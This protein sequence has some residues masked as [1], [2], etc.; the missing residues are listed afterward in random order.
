MERL[1]CLSVGL[2]AAWIFGVTATRLANEAL[3]LAYLWRVLS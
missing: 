2:A 3:W 1:L